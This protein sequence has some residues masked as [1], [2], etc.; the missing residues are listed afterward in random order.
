MRDEDIDLLTRWTRCL[1]VHDEDEDGIA[2]IV[3]KF[4]I[5]DSPEEMRRIFNSMSHDDACSI[6]SLYVHYSCI[7]V[8]DFEDDW[9]REDSGFGISFCLDKDG[10]IVIEG[11]YRT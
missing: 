7:G 6:A 10:F 3:V 11:N 9:K 8:E 4:K 5:R 2:T 1:E